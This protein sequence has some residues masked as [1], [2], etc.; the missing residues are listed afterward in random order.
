MSRTECRAGGRSWRRTPLRPAP[1]RARRHR[2]LQR[3]GGEKNNACLRESAATVE[4]GS[5]QTQ[6]RVAGRIRR[7]TAFLRDTLHGRG[8]RAL[9]CAARGVTD[10]AAHRGANRFTL[11]SYLTNRMV[12]G[13]R[14]NCP[15]DAF[16]AATMARITLAMPMTISSGMPTTMTQSGMRQIV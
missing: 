8:D 9:T 12:S 11:S 15:S 6:A 3:C 13:Y 16:I 5:R 7:V 10:G 14:K 1:T 2:R 4:S